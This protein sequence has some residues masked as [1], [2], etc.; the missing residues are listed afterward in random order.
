MM[1]T[2]VIGYVQ[3]SGNLDPNLCVMLAEA[4]AKAA[5]H[6]VLLHVLQPQPCEGGQDGGD[7]SEQHGSHVWSYRAAQTPWFAPLL[8]AR[9][10]TGKA[11]KHTGILSWQ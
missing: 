2:C 6:A 5:E 1:M 3:A 9:S 4:A 10:K 11:L 7:G 8:E